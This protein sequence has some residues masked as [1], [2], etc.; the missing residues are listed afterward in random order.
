MGTGA[1]VSGDVDFEPPLISAVRARDTDCDP[2]FADA[3]A[4]LLYDAERPVRVLAVYGLA[5]HDDE[6][7]VAG[8]RFPG[9]A[10]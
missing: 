8:K 10:R 6:R 4:G 5:R 3:M 1:G 9:A 2:A 7:C